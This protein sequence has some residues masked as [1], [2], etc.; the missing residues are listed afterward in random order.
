MAD[1][2]YV[3]MQ[4]AARILGMGRMTLWRRVQEGALSV[5]RLERDRRVK[6]V[7]RADVEAMLTPKIESPVANRKEGGQ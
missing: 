1:D 5:Y 4:E 2:E 7:K 6:L 3:T